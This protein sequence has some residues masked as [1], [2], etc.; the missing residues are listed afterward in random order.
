[1]QYVSIDIETTGLDKNKHQIVEIGAVIDSLGSTTPLKGLPKFRAVLIHNEMQMGAYC[2]N[3]HRDLW[4]EILAVKRLQIAPHNIIKGVYSQRADR[5]NQADSITICKKGRPNYSVIIDK[6][7]DE[8][9]YTY[10]M[11]PEKFEHQFK[12]WLAQH[13]EFNDSHKMI[14]NVAGKNPGSFDIP[15]IEALPNW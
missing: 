10:Y 9:K 4:A 13:I 15:F 1:M 7:Y 3:L 12:F 6:Y 11:C 14:I 8:A 2:A 5:I